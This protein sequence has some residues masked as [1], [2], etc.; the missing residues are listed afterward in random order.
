M[1]VNIIISFMF[2]VCFGQNKTIDGIVAIV[3]DNIILK[4]DLSQMISITAAQNRLNLNE[5]TVYKNL[6]NSIINSMIDQKVI[7]EMALLDSVVVDESEVDQALEQQIENLI[8]ESSG[9]ENAEKLLGQSINSF[10]REFWYEMQNRL[11][12]ERY[13]QT[14]LSNI[15]LT[16]K[17]VEY[18]FETY[19]DSL[20]IVP[21]KV[22]LYHILIKVKPSNQSKQATINK[23]TILRE[24]LI[25]REVS[26]SEQ[27]KLYSEDTGSKERGGNLGWVKRGSLV[28]N[29]ENTAFTLEIN[30]IS[31]PIETEFG[32]HI[33]ET[34]DK[35]GEKIKVRHILV[36]PRIT[37]LDTEN[38]Y[39]FLDSLRVNEIKSIVDFKNFSEKFNEDEK[40]RKTKG[41]LGWVVPE[42]FYI[43]EI[44]KAI[45]Y[46]DINTCSPPIHSSLGIHLL[47]I[48]D[49]KE[50]GLLNLKDHYSEVESIALNYKKA[51]W[52]NKWVEDAKS[53]FYIYK[54]IY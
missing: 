8:F 6:E 43:E 18:F 11:I 37:E 44:G 12:T 41:N 3:E 45:N 53:K 40:T 38:V 50:G 1:K 21:T 42:T 9:K 30:E 32:F 52:F 27:A 15:K 17:D 4:S 33:L 31:N 47:W 49:V 35:K 51:K 16:R 34:L 39:K 14:L 25:Q 48:K 20:P 19:K 7:L 24:K 29:F 46:L 2:C 10:R 13:Q 22:Q 28:K 26:F 36:K 5:P 23:L 54:H